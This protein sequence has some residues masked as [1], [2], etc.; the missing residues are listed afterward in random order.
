MTS[1]KEFH[2]N[3]NC[4][5]PCNEACPESFI[6]I[7][8]GLITMSVNM[9]AGDVIAKLGLEPHPEGG[10]YR[11]TFVSSAEPGQ[12]PAGSVIHY[13]LKAGES[14][15]WHRV[16]ADE[17]WFYHSGEPL[18]LRVSET[19]TGPACIITLGPC[20]DGAMSMQGV[21]PKGWWQAAKPLGAWTLVSCTVSPAFSFDGF[22][23][24]EP[25]FDIPDGVQ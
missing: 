17:I 3:E 4:F 2:S 11:Q 10:W 8:A 14:S 13:L 7:Y 6:P 16:D 5:V 20:L 21:V 12:R 25:G 23:L 9:S 22:E 18:Q 19:D 1:V 24:A 15:H